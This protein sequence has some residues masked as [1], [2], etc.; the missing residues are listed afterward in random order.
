MAHE[1]SEERFT[2][3]HQI[4]GH[5]AVVGAV[6][7]YLFL[8]LAATLL[9]AFATKWHTTILPEGL[10][11]KWF[12]QL[13][14]DP[15][16]LEALG[17]TL[18]VTVGTM[19]LAVLVTVPAVFT[20]IVYLP[21]YEKVLQ[22]LVMLPYAIPG[23]VAAVGL[24]RAYAGGPVP[25]LVV[26]VGSYFVSILPFMYQGIRNSLGA[27]QANVLVDAAELLGATKAQAFWQV[28]VPNILPG[29]F[30]SSLLSFS[31]LF[32]EFVLTNLLVGGYFETIQ[33]YLY[34][35]M[36]ESGHLS[37][38]IVVSYF[39]LIAVLGSV[40]GLFNKKRGRHI[41]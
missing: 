14:S 4:N 28:I 32:G 5:Q 31:V 17:R 39:L 13:Y 34:R 1:K 2:M 9:Y 22:I 19:V 6:M 27:V 10:T 15:R 35:R 3:N 16:F 40:I 12:A 25:M 24:I 36:S 21:N 29:I 11:V 37:S 30:V 7:A 26:L 38:A 33:I 20:V 23:V 18:M 8:P 41:N